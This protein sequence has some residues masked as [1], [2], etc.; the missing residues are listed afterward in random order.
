MLT[1]AANDFKTVGGQMML[2]LPRM[3][4]PLTS[5]TNQ[6]RGPRIF[7]RRQPNSSNLVTA[8]HL[9]LSRER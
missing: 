6:R 7:D 3:P 5:P 1:D 4:A 8:I 9:P 2:E